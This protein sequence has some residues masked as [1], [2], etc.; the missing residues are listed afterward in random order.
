MIPI[1][2]DRN[3]APLRI[4][5]LGAH[6]DDIEIG[7]GATML[8]LL[9]ERPGS[10]VV[11]VALASTPERAQEARASAAEFLADAGDSTV[12]IK[13]FR[14]SYFPY[15]GGEIKD[16]F[17]ELKRIVNPDLIFTHRRADEHQD[18]QIVARLTWNTFRD[19]L[20]AE[21]EIPKYEG[22]LGHPNLYVPLDVTT[23]DRKVELLLR[24]FPSQLNRTWF[25]ADTF[26][27][28]MAMRGVE[29][30]SPSGFAE[31]LHVRKL[32]M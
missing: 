6:C 20:I 24:H 16:Y 31:A 7:C 11:W 5:C 2:I 4:L 32:T 29:C 23:V 18:H 28:L 25:R 21:Y 12:I 17:E 3:S 14:E 19:H 13:T 15:V 10:L 26:R 27:G 30:N 9:S 22:D 8:R 1:A